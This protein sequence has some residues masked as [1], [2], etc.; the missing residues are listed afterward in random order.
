MTTKQYN[1]VKNMRVFIIVLSGATLIFFAGAFFTG[2]KPT[3]ANYIVAIVIL[4]NL[5]N[6]IITKPPTPPTINA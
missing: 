3:L 6:A 4:L 2:Y 5:I 1:F